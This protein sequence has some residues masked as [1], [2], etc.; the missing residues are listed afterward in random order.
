MDLESVADQ[1]YGLPPGEFIE[2]RR[3][4]VAEAR[5][6]KDGALAARIGKLGRPTLAAW[7]S[8]LLVRSDP[9]QVAALLRL[10]EGLRQA[11]EQL[12]GEQLRELSRRQHAVVGALVRQARQRAAEAGHPVTETVQREVEA[13]LH[14]V[15]ADPQAAQEWAGGHLVKSLSPPVG[16]TA[17]AVAG[18]PARAAPPPA[19]A[20]EPVT[21]VADKPRASA[22]DKSREEARRRKLAEARRDAEAAEQQA[23]EQEEELQEAEAQ[24]EQA[25]TVLKEARERAAALA[26]ELS[27]AQ[28]AERRTRG[29]LDD[30]RRQEAEA[31][32]LARKARRD[33]RTARTRADRLQSV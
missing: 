20:P 16:F 9:D 14:A 11:H 25:E 22:K 7:A 8:N 33:A 24:R 32:R 21:P 26:R 13:T 4:Y 29:A 27:A 5:K 18:A 10:G 19:P 17:A 1:L 12:D 2:A 23:R 15:L 31:G 6:A 3:S 30:A 28:E